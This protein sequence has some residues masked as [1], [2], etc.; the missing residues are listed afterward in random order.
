MT[1]SGTDLLLEIARCPNVIKILEGNKYH[2]CHEIVKS[3]EVKLIDDFQIPEPW[4]GNIETARLLYLS[5]NPSISDNDEKELYPTW[6]WPE[7]RIQD[8][9]NHRFG[10]SKEQWVKNGKYAKKQEGLYMERHQPYWTEMM[11]RSEELYGREVVPGLDYA[12]TEIVHCKSK[13]NC[14][15]KVA[16]NE[17]T[18]RY[19]QRVLEISGASVIAVVGDKAKKGMSIILDRLEEQ[20][21]IQPQLI[22]GKERIILF[23]AAPNSNKPRKIEKVLPPAELSLVR[24][25]LK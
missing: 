9:F 18:G 23:L 12:F 17:C 15:V 10:G 22:A 2:P 5:S 20:H 8:F 19:L 14:G 4:N 24:S 7:E 16:C 11:N 3:Q 13:N 6:N 21:F 25:Y 1:I